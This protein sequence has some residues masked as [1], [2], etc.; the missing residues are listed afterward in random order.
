MNNKKMI[1]VIVPMYNE[2]KRAK[3]FLESLLDI[4][5]KKFKEFEVIL[6]N[7]GSS[8]GTLAMLRE[9]SKKNV[10][11]I[12][13]KKN[14]GK[15]FA[16][17]QGFKKAVGEF[18]L[19]IDADGSISPTEIP[20]MIEKL[21]DFDVVIGCR[22]PKKTNI[23]RPV[24]RTFISQAFNLIANTLFGLRIKDIACGFKGFRKEVAA[25]LIKNIKS[26]KWNIDTEML[27]KAKKAG[28]SIYSLPVDWT[29]KKGSNINIFSS[30]ELLVE[31]IQIRMFL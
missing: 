18:I 9:F 1:S 21:K 31:L 30:L 24:M 25:G 23:V 2:E 7:D 15:A 19:F 4:C 10:R 16:I 17:T 12:S 29:Y 14:I 8:D 5:Q 27:Y 28:Y 26:Q 20:K 11:I 13:Y 6:V 3:G 22:N